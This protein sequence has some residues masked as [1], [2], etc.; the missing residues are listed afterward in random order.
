MASRISPSNARATRNRLVVRLMDILLHWVEPMRFKTLR[1]RA[2]LALSLELVEKM[3]AAIEAGDPDKIADIT[4]QRLIILE[5]AL[6]EQSGR[7]LRRSRSAAG[8]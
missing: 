5:R 6:E 3:M 4:E 2:D 7:R 1:S 8:V